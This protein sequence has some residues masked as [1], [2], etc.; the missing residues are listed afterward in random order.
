MGKNKS[1]GGEKRKAEGAMETKSASLFG[2]AKDEGLSGLFSASV[3]S[4]PH[5][6]EAP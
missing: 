5:P 6:C 3:S 1:K 4:C 2:N